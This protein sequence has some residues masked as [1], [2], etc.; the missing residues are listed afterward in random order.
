MKRIIIIGSKPRAIIP[1]GD[2]IYCA[3]GAIGYYEQ[4]VRRFESVVCILNPD[5]IHPKKRKEGSPTKDFYDRQYSAI[6]GSRP[7]KLILLRNTS[8]ALLTE[9]LR[10]SRF[11]APIHSLSTFERR[12]LVGKISGLYDPIVTGDFFQ[13]QT[14]LQIR[15]TGSLISTFF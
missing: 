8:Q 2:V 14:S 6:A 9:E 11:T 4:S 15:Y 1:E 10:Y 12:I 5:L 13:L 3:N 7:D